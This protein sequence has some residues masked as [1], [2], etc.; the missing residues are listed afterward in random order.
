MISKT[1]SAHAGRFRKASAAHLPGAAPLTFPNTHTPAGGLVVFES[2]REQALQ[3]LRALLERCA[4]LG[5]ADAV[6][7]DVHQN[8]AAPG[9][10]R[11]H[12]RLRPELARTWAPQH[13]T[14]ALAHMLARPADGGLDA[15]LD[16]D[17]ALERE[18]VACLLAAPVAFE[19]P[20]QR[21]AWAAVQLRKNIVRAAR[22]TEL[23]FDT[24][25][26]ERPADYWTYDEARG[27]TVLPGRSV[28]DAL[29]KATQPDA[30]GTLYSF[31]C[32]RA[33]EYVTLLGL[34]E[35]LADFNPALLQALQR[36]WESRAIMSGL[37]H[38]VFLREYGSMDQPLPPRFYIPGDRLWFRNP[39][40]HS[41]NV[42]G[43]EGSWVF[44]IG[45]GLFTNFWKRN[46]PYTLV[47][48]CLEIYHW[49]DG[50]RGD[51]A[52][53]LRM[54]E[55]V[56]E[57]RVR[58]TLADP[59]RIAAILPRMMRWREPRGVY[60]DGGCLDTTRECLRWIC[61]GT[62]DLVLPLPTED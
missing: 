31:S 20:G 41:A 11:A 5:L 22:R 17:V 50:V 38:D 9:R 48:K 57:A 47:S 1:P 34:A 32:Y 19:Y 42:E 18:I 8:H 49:R 46:Q 10:W 16:D 59:A 27:F 24:E 13:D 37:F 36:Q 39:D 54:D 55:G 58:E 26:A 45:G 56:V 25:H 12:L 23:A 4:E 6:Q 35:T 60:R 51:A 29:R 30:S 3:A 62:A 2:T 44:Y 61:P 33:T 21:E 28:T 52:G 53:R 15:S 7:G 40:E 43:Y 14:I